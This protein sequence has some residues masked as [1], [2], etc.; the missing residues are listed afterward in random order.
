M[1][2]QSRYIEKISYTNL[3][4]LT[5]NYA[6]EITS[7]DFDL[8]TGK[9]LNNLDRNA[10]VNPYFVEVVSSS[11]K[12]QTNVNENF[13]YKY[14]Q[15]LE[16][17]SMRDLQI[18]E[19]VTINAVFVTEGASMKNMFGYYFYEYDEEGNKRLLDNESMD[20]EYYYRPTVIFPNVTSE[21]GDNR[22]LQQGESRRLRGN[23]PNGNFSD[24]HVGFFLIC[25]GWYAFITKTT[26]NDDKILHSTLEFNRV[27]KKSEYQMVNDK[28][29][30]IYTRASNSEN[31]ELLLVGFED[32]FFKGTYDMDYN[33]CVIG[34]EISDVNQVKDYDKFAKII[35]ETEEVKNN[36]INIDD[37]G[38]Y[39][40]LDKNEHHLTNSDDYLFERHMIFTYESD[41]NKFY[42]IYAKLLLNY[43]LSLRTENIDGKYKIICTHLFRKN[44][45]IFNI[46]KTKVKLYLFKIGFNKD[47]KILMR[48]YIDLYQYYLSSGFYSEKYRLYS[49]KTP[50]SEIIR[51]DDSYDLSCRG[52][53]LNFRI[54]GSGVMDC[55]DGKS[56]LPFKNPCI[57]NVYKNVSYGNTG[58]S[59]NVKMDNH[60]DDY[61]RDT[62]YFVRYISF[63][64]DSERHVIVDLGNLEIYQED[65]DKQLVRVENIDL[66]NSM[67]SGK[68]NVSDIMEGSD[69]D[70]KSII[71]ILANDKSSIF[72]IITI[73]KSLK[74]Y[75]I[76]LPSVKNNPIVVFLE[77]DN[78][79]GWMDNI[80]L[81]GGTY[82]KKNKFYVVTSFKDLG[83]TVYNNTNNFDDKDDRDKDDESDD[84]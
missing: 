34:L 41:R 83:S 53:K 51:L 75:C 50:S 52:S 69:Y 77:S 66:F 58:L 31:E 57:Y 7:N 27:Y 35:F 72:R 32:I 15:V 18:L 22:T 43:K 2:R 37:E 49:K 79:L 61:K 44:D 81:L 48:Q 9:P 60:P 76:R 63:V 74:F 40:L 55:L 82:Y 47:Y 62:K 16:L 84:D 33:D 19:E 78:I 38:E 64:I 42:E 67:N 21:P 25:F 1:S 65:M 5:E 29:Y 71:S 45:I 39:I 3:N 11:L 68:I 13:I 24:V 10:K 46:S 59:I 14:P 56:H 36:F 23:L 17:D 70:I 4:Y 80:S 6:S 28:I 12:E 26:I 54:I 30:S 20:Q 8:E 73:N